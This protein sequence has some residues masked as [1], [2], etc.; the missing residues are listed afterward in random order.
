VAIP[1]IDPLSRRGLSLV[2]EGPYTGAD[3]T[4]ARRFGLGVLLIAFPIV[5]V[6]AV[7]FPPTAAVGPA[8]WTVVGVLA[9]PLGASIILV[10]RVR[11]AATFHVLLGSSYMCAVGAGV[12]QW[13]AGGWQTPYHHLY[14]PL[15]VLV[16]LIHPPSRTATYLLF[17]EVS[18][19]APVVV[20]G[21]HGRA[22]DIAV[23]STMWILIALFCTFL[24][25]GVRRQRAQLLAGH[26]AAV[27]EA[28]RDALTHLENRRSFDETIEDALTRANTTAGALTLAVGD[29]DH[30]KSINDRHG[31]LEGDRC[32]QEVAVALRTARRVGDRVFRWGGDEFAVLLEGASEVEARAVC[33][34]LEDEVAASVSTPDGKP[35]RITFGWAQEDGAVDGAC[36][37]ARAD[38]ALMARKQHRPRPVAA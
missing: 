23:G 37:V 20:G 19:L 24:M 4:N 32:L 9:A 5:V 22:S 28:R 36:L 26:E 11:G 10:A 3:V 1:L 38:A 29:I 17:A 30:F 27:D 2:R 8:G 13:L 21:T 6:L 35:V 12:L 33:A 25:A 15:M 34:R 7:L 31:H 18:L 14:L 16:A